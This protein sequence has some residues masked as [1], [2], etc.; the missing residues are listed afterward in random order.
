MIGA[1]QWLVSLG[2]F[3]IA[4]AAV[5]ALSRFRAA[6]RCGHMDRVRHLYGYICKFSHACIRVR[7]GMSGYSEL[8]DQFYD[9]GHSVYGKVHEHISDDIPTPLGKP[10]LTTTYVDTNLYHC[11]LTGR[12]TTGILHLMSGTCLELVL[13]EVIYS[14]DCC[15]WFWVC[16]SRIATDQIIDIHIS[17]QYLGVPVHSKSYLFGDN[18][19][20]VTSS[21]IP[22]SGLNKRHNALSYH[23]VHEAIAAEILAFIHVDG[24]LNVADV[25]S[26]HCGFQQAWPLIKPLLFWMGNT[27]ECDVKGEKVEGA[28][29]KAKMKMDWFVCWF[30]SYAP[31]GSE[32]IP[33]LKGCSPVP[34]IWYVCGYC[35]FGTTKFPLYVGAHCFSEVWL[36]AGWKLEA[37]HC[38]MLLWLLIC[39][40]SSTINK[41]PAFGWT[42]VV[43]ITI[44]LLV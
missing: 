44:I 16:G 35:S 14:G 25:L 39:A 33:K 31:K 8:D 3:D 22:H 19:S 9:W 38:P 43:V 21:T 6:P 1:C 2:R 7:T 12:A 15:L 13:Q 30:N 17:L 28:S 42:F 29:K 27:L 10:M 34:I 32:T 36:I 24:K 23:H 4:A 37:M 20:V 18:Q 41:G 40:T 11:L 26:K 5:S